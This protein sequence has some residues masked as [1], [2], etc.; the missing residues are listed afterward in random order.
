MLFTVALLG[1]G[2]VVVG[3]LGYLWRHRD[4]RLTRGVAD[5]AVSYNV[6]NGQA[7]EPTMPHFSQTYDRPKDGS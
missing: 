1:T 4:S 2:A 3:T 7:A 6:F 5:A